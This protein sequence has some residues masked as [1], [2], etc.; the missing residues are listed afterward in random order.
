MKPRE[1]YRLSD[2]SLDFFNP[3]DVELGRSKKMIYEVAA[4]LAL[5]ESGPLRPRESD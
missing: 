1:Q 4:I 5:I 3:L 2:D